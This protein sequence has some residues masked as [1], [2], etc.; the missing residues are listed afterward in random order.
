MRFLKP[1]IAILALTGME[2]DVIGK[3]FS[4][5]QILRGIPPSDPDNAD[6]KGTPGGT[7][8]VSVRW[9]VSTERAPSGGKQPNQTKSRSRL[10]PLPEIYDQVA[11]RSKTRSPVLPLSS[12]CSSPVR[13]LSVDLPGRAPEHHLHHSRC[14][15]SS[16]HLACRLLC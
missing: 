15:D 7:A 8:Q 2:L 14:V 12:L 5:L 1:L 6:A 13:S 10:H 3:P 11:V 4:P 16:L 9:N